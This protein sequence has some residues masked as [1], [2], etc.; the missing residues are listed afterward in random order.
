MKRFEIWLVS[1]DPTLGPEMT[2]TRPAMILSPDE[3]NGPLQTLL[4][5]PLT[6]SLKPWPFRVSISLTQEPGQLCLDQL[7]SVSK[8][9]LVKKLGE[10]QA[11][12]QRALKVLRQLFS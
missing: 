5:A 7:R 2:K 6:P 9:R 4:V 1:L 11:V 10:D 12:G 3:L 8:K